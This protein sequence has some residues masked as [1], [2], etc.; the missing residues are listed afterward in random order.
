VAA[1]F[2]K[3]LTGENQLALAD[4]MK[5][6][7]LTVTATLSGGQFLKTCRLTSASKLDILYLDTIR[8]EIQ[9]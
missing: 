9:I 4:G 2:Y 8:K 7:G 3:L 6:D 1:L 5:P